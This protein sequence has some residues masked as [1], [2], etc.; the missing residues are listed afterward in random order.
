MASD[1]ITNDAEAREYLAALD[2]MAAS[3]QITE[4]E[5]LDERARV[6]TLMERWERGRKFNRIFL[7]S[8]FGV[9]VLAAI[10]VFAVTSSKPKSVGDRQD[11][12]RAAAIVACRDAI[13]DQLKAPRTAEFDDESVLWSGSEARV[14]GAVDA[15]N[16]FGALIRTQW[17]CTVTMDLDGAKAQRVTSAYLDD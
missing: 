9:L 5:C 17:S 13:K 8:L 10:I 16:S 6:L 11:D 4:D 2:R 1:R 12:A 3:G 7:I 15:Q 14:S